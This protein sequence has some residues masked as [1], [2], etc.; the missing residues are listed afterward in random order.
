MG[1]TEILIR[2]KSLNVAI[3]ACEAPTLNNISEEDEDNGF[4][5]SYYTYGIPADSVGLA[6]EYDSRFC[7]SD[8]GEWGGFAICDIQENAIYGGQWLIKKPFH[9]EF[10]TK[11]SFARACIRRYLEE[12]GD[13]PEQAETISYDLVWEWC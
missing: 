6:D 7:I 12:I 9:E 13:D 5:D 4:I 3:Y 10:E 11:D 2:V 1:C 8:C